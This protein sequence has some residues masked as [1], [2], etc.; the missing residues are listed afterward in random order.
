MAG[1]DTVGNAM[2]N[3]KVTG[4]TGIAHNQPQTPPDITS[5]FG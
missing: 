5:R 3:D 4:A 2:L 1:R